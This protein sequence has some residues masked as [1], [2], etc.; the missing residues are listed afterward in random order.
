[1]DEERG[2]AGGGVEEPGKPA[3]S[4][5]LEGERGGGKGLELPGGLIE[6]RGETEGCAEFVTAEVVGGLDGGA[7]MAEEVFPAAMLEGVME[8]A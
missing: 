1:M 8:F 6:E 7:P 2:V 5:Q 4:R 3:L